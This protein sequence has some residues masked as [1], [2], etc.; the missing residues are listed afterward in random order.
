MTVSL[1]SLYSLHADVDIAVVNEKKDE[2]I[3][4]KRVINYERN[5]H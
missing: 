5:A 2:N 4:K 3:L 1:K